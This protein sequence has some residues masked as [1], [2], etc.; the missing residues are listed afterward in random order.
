MMMKKRTRP[1]TPRKRA[2]VRRNLAKRTEPKAMSTNSTSTTTC[3]KTRAATSTTK[4][5][6]LISP[7]KE[8]RLLL[9]PPR[10]LLEA[11]ATQK[12]LRSRSS[13]TMR[14]RKALKKKPTLISNPVA[15][16]NLVAN[17]S[18]EKLEVR[19]VAV[20]RLADTQLTREGKSKEENVQVVKEVILSPLTSRNK[21]RR[22]R[23]T[24][25]L[26]CPTALRRTA[27]RRTQLA[28]LAAHCTERCRRRTKCS[29]RCTIGTLLLLA[30]VELTVRNR[31]SSPEAKEDAVVSVAAS[32][33]QPTRPG[34]QVAS[35]RR[36]GL[37]L[38]VVAESLSRVEVSAVPS[39][40]RPATTS[41][42]STS[43]P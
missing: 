28:Q 34:S 2:P 22:S 25:G 30:P 10:H 15:P 35:S 37:L 13:L 29:H 36:K 8:P 1:T 18:R 11:P 40:L 42:N 41:P 3:G 17:S 5:S 23:L 27:L 9:P 33:P 32:V 39:T 24:P 12:T 19:A 38:R 4:L 7:T 6:T 21:N 26:M 43:S 20:D 16:A 31:A 14:Q